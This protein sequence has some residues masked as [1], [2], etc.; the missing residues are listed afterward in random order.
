MRVGDLMNPDVEAV[1]PDD[2]LKAAAQLMEHLGLEAL[3]VGQDNLLVGTITG[4][5]VALQVA[6]GGGDAENLRVGE[7]MSADVL[8]CFANEK[9]QLVSAKMRDWWVRRLP[10]V[11][12]DKRLLGTVSLGDLTPLK[13]RRS[14]AK[15]VSSRRRAKPRATDR[16]PTGTAAA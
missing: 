5:D 1:A 7:A 3:P 16:R 12:P 6:A 9:A 2:T 4:H 11:G 14:R 8:Y 13:S 15:R 10:V